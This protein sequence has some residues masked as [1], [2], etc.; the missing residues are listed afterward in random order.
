MCHEADVLLVY[1]PPYLP[2]FN[3][4]ESSFSPLKRWIK[5]HSNL[6]DFYQEK[7]GGF[8]QFLYDIIGELANDIEHAAG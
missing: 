6:I 1:L 8:G 4:I 7:I 2:N 3:P 5:R